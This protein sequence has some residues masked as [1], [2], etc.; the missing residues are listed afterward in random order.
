MPI[1]TP[2][3]NGFLPYGNW[4]LAF[5]APNPDIDSGTVPLPR[6]VDMRRPIRTMSSA[7]RPSRGTRSSNALPL[8]ISASV[9]YVGTRTDGT[10]TVRN[11][12][13]AESGGN[14]N[15]LSWALVMA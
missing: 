13:Y 8:D 1:A 10:Y 9:G 7:A 3:L 14:A 5:L 11:L 6:G 2:A 4:R 12:N 15:R